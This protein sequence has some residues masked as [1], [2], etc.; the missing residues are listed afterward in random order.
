MKK[1]GVLAGVT[2]G[3]LWASGHAYAHGDEVHA[4]APKATN[5]G[6]VQAA[7]TNYLE[8]VVVKNSKDAS[9]NPVVVFI[10]DDHGRKLPSA[11]ATGTATLLSGKDKVVVTLAPDG[12]NRMKG[13]GKY[14]SSPS[15]KTIVAFTFPG[16]ATVQAR[17][18]PLAG[19]ADGHTDHKH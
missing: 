7:G 14:A 11:G 16:K 2:L 1:F 8:L 12:D 10:T 3:L 6:Q 4:E 15:L 13:S 5:G 17:F 19:N 18:T 9:D